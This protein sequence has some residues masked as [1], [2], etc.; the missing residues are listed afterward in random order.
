MEAG[1]T[2]SFDYEVTAT[3]SEP[4]DSGFE[5]T[6]TITVQNP[7][8][9]AISGVTI[10]DT[11]PNATCTVPGGTAATIT[12]GVHEF[13]YSCSLTN[14]SATT[15]GT[16]TAKVTWNKASY[17][18]TSGA[19]QATKAYDFAAV[20]PTTTGATA[21]V[22][23]PLRPQRRGRG[24]LRGGH[25]RGE[26]EGLRLHARARLDCGRVP[27]VHQH[28]LD[29]GPR[30]PRPECPTTVTVCA[31]APPPPAPPVEPPA[32]PVV[33]PVAPPVAPPVPVEVLPAQAF[34]KAVGQVRASCQG[35]VRAT[36][37]NASGVR[38]TYKLRVG[39]KVHSIK[40]EVAGQEEVPDL[41]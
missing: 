12:P 17:H 16:N 19:A 31:P 33:P 24:H 29:D 22:R 40:V 4:Q 7:N 10:L 20:T 6:G 39:K 11:M 36:L 2:A 27:P 32:P 21:T 23:R 30:R 9:T 25:P 8:A 1:A 15:A 41:G 34:G 35:T 3:A 14:G 18:G 5:V 26:P 37:D 38:V 13:A 28:R